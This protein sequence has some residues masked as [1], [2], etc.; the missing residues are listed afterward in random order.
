MWLLN[1]EQTEGC[2]IK[3]ARCG[4]E[5]GPPEL[6]KYCVEGY[7]TVTKT[8]YEIFS[9]FY[10][11]DTRQPIRDVN[12]MCGHALTERFEHNFA[13]RTDNASRI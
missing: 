5:Y 3:H 6:P 11:G 7:C 2:R 4:R 1:M 10:H 12:T 13:I 8:I 9:C